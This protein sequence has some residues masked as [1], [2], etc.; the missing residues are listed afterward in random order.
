METTISEDDALTS[1]EPKKFV[2][3][4]EI[5][6]TST[7]P[8]PYDLIDWD[9]VEALPIRIGEDGREYLDIPIVP[10]TEEEEKKVDYWAMSAEVFNRDLEDPANAWWKN[11]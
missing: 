1:M 7:D 6:W 11:L 2:P 4:D 8:H 10:M 3:I 9:D 5:D